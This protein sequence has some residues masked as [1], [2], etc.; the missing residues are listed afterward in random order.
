M[1]ITLSR[2]IA[3]TPAAAWE[4]L[5]T[6]RTWAHWGPT[7][8]AVEPAEAVLTDG[9]EG[10]VRTPIGLWLPFRITQLDRYHSWTWSVCGIPGTSH[11]VD[12]VPGGCRV[13]FAV[14]G[15]AIPYLLICRLALQRIAAILE[16]GA[17]Q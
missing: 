10:R 9:M 17:G 1:M 7:V 6:T 8:T 3:A 5:T 16:A 4:L 13:T 14:P 15:L 12:A 11:R 2:R